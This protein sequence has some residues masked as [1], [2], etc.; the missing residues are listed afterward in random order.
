[1]RISDWS[2]D[3]CSSDLVMVVVVDAYGFGS[4]E[5][6]DNR[7]RLTPTR[8]DLMFRTRDQRMQAVKDLMRTVD[9]LQTRE[10]VRADAHGRS[11]GRRVGKEGVSTGKYR[12]WAEH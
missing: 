10:D 4:R 11:E 9:Y 8:P 6:P 3:V 5:T 1:M 7:G 12:W 2:S